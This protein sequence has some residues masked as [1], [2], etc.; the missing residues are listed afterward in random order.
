MP[1][2]EQ[3]FPETR[4]FLEDSSPDAYERLIDRLLDSPRYGERWARHWLDVAGYSDSEGVQH[5]DPVRP[6]AWR[7]R[8]YVIR[9]FNEDKPYDRFLSEQLAGDELADHES[10]ESITQ[11]LEDQLVA[12]GFLRMAA[13]G[14]FASITNFVPDRL[15]VIDAEVEVLSS[16]TMGMT[17]K[18]ARCHDHRFDPIS[19]RD[20]YGLTA[21]LKGAYDEHDWLKPHDTDQFSYGDFGHRYLPHVESGRLE[22]W[23]AREERLSAEIEAVSTR[24]DLAEAP[25]RARLLE[26]AIAALPEVLHADLRELV[27]TAPEQRSE[28]QRYLYEKFASELEPERAL[29]LERDEDFR[30][31]VEE[32][33]PELARLEGE[34]EARPQIR[35]LWDRGE[36]SPTFLLERGEYLAPGEL[37]EPGMPAVLTGAGAAY[38]VEP[39]WPGAHKTGRRLALARWLT[40][41]E[42]PLTARVLVNRVWKHHFGRGIVST[43]DNFGASGARPT[44]PELLDWLALELVEGDW[45]IKRLHRLLMC[46]STYRQVSATTPEHARLDPD[47]ALL[48]R[49]PLA[50]LDAEA[51]YDSL[52]LVAGRLDETPYGPADGLE[53]REDGLVTP[54]GTERGWRRSIYVLQRRTLPPSLHES[55]DLP[56]MSPNCVERPSSTVATQALHMLNNGRV[57]D[58]ARDLARRV[59]EE[60]GPEPRAQIEHMYQLALAR[61]PGPEELS[62]QLEAHERL[63]EQWPVPV[64]VGADEEED[65]ALLGPLA[66]LCHAMLNSAEFCYLD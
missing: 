33:E 11:E 22:A 62:L 13:D 42:H 51:L 14:T 12:T 4:A 58:L 2:L 60:A 36:P 37:V 54:V 43:L 44:H 20:Y 6:E 59:R 17:F 47:N 28:V 45:S 18:C 32:L 66:N 31:L 35:A 21:V 26:E 3:P 8:D 9:A 41:P 63:R 57:H 19:Q 15:G 53:V 16:A 38:R 55:F 61:A 27:D 5:S 23:R 10:A 24:L 39:P 49:M 56:R 1:Q 46:S 50:R 65:L 7:Y 25:L 29:L 34:R 48:S 40:Q 52:L 30:M 64:S